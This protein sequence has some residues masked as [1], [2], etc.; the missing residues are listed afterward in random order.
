MKWWAR[1]RRDAVALSL[2]G[3]SVT[4]GEWA[5][6]IDRLAARLVELGVRPGDRINGCGANS[7]EYCTLAFAAMR[8]GAI[9]APLNARFTAHELAEIVVDHGSRLI[10]ADPDQAE[11]FVDTG[12]PVH[13][14]AEVGALRKGGEAGIAHDPQ[15]DD[16]VVIISTSG[17]TAKPKGVMFSHRTMLGYITANAMEDGAL[18]DGGGV[19]VVAPLATSAGMV[20][21]IHYAAMGCTLYFEPHFDAQRFLDILVNRKIVSFGGAPAFFERI[22]ALPSFKDADLSHLKVVTV[23]GARVTRDLFDAW[24]AKGKT[25]RQVYGQTEVGGNSTIMPGFLAAE[26]PEKCGWGGIFT[27]HRIVDRD[28][29]TLPPNT[30]GEILVRGPGMM[31]GYWNNPKATAETIRDGWLHTGDI[32]TI[33]E[34]GLITFVDRLKDIVISGGL[35]IS[36]AEVERAVL[37]FPGVEEA[38]VI[39]APDARFQETPLA[40]VYGR[41]EIDVA[42]L[43]AHCNARLADYKVP[44]YVAVRREPLPRLATQ[45]ISKPALREEYA[46]AHLTLPRVR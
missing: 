18:R 23:G 15:S 9:I 43:I 37:D 12:V 41:A 3:D 32:G 24:A 45:K 39:A 33:D 16:C 13:G 21:L 29:N 30:E 36:A 4:Y 42:A 8:A 1:N 11:K 46:E 26:F 35:N 10:F 2:G 7:L 17:S 25:I 22:A 40:V 31:L 44:R 34:R 14:F 20:Q 6:W 19:I 5:G 28:G 27:E 38:A